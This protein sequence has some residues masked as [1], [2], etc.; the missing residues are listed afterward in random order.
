MAKVKRCL[1]VERHDWETGARAHQLQFPLAVA[2]QF[3]GSG[4]IDRNIR[5][6]V[7]APGSGTTPLFQR[8]I[9]ISRI[10]APSSTRRTNRLLEMGTLIPPSF[11]FF[12]ETASPGVYDLWWQA[13]KAV[14]AAKYHPWIQGHSGGPGRRGRLAIIVQAPV[15]RVICKI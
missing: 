7:F 4:N 5:V 10:Y 13:D 9:T 6:R 14:V 12:E 11:V 15:P 1:I 3:F 2:D 8:D